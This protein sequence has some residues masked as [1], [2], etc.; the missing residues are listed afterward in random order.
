MTRPSSLFREAVASAGAAAGAAS[1]LAWLGPPGSDLAAHAYQRAVFIQH[2]FTLWN[3]FWYA[4]RYSFINY[5]VLYYPLAAVFGIRPLAVLSVAVAALAFTVVVTREW[6]RAARWSTRTFAIVWAG[7]VLS[8]SF[9]FA[10]G[11]AFAL[12]ALW[13]IQSGRRWCFAALAALALAASPLAFL[14]LSLVLAGI[15]IAR[16]PIRSK[17]FVPLAAVLVVGL[18][19]LVL[20]RLFPSGGR[21]PFSTQEFFAVCAFCLLGAAASWRVERAR[22]L[23]AI[24]L[25]YLAACLTLYLI[26]TQV[27]ENIARLRLAA[28]PLAVLTLSLRSW[29]PIPVTVLV[30]ALAVSWNTTPFAFSFV[31][32]QSDPAAHAAYW[33]PTIRFLEHHLSPAYRVE[34]VDTTGHWPAV[35]LPKAGIPLARGWYRQNDFSQNSVLYRDFGAKAYLAWLRRLGVR[36]VVLT[37]APTDYSSQDEKALL[38]GNRSGLRIVFWDDHVTVYA[39]PRPVPLLTG[40]GRGEVLALTQTRVSLRLADPG[41]YHLAVSYSPY[42]T[43]S[44]G[45]LARSR[46]GMIQLTALWPGAVEL[47]FHVNAGSAFAVLAGRRP[48]ACAPSAGG[49]HP[50]PAGD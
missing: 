20:W 14:L 8:A 15:A 5:S 42:W 48:S 11:A 35:Y 27:G 33:Q 28:V 31:S 45:C 25:V 30:L 13:A 43:I 6:G 7:I 9:P 10:L 4:G 36:Y 37:D 26:P 17:L 32:G 22:P 12:L 49:R 44:A 47:G 29:R 1:L 40:H 50:G 41:V 24:F 34:A 21:Y 16:R 2:G 38:L 18:L 23:F 39:V 3:N 19:E 46:D